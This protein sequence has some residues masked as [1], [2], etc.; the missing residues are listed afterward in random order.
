MTGQTEFA[1]GEI[2]RDELVNVATDLPADKW[3]PTLARMVD[4]YT[5]F[6]RK[7]G[8][9]DDDA[10]N[11]AQQLVA[12]LARDQGGRPLYLPRGD[13]LQQALVARQIFH[14]HR[15]NNVDELADRFGYTVRH[16]QR[17]YAEQRA[18][19]VRKVQPDLFGR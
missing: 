7:H 9:S 13:R 19:H 3:V 18:L 16:V 10:V 14:L 6:L 12:L 1:L 11:E 17:I 8:R 15:G 4:L 2:G 5:D